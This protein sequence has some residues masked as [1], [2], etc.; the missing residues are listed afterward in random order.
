MSEPH[1]DA[2]VAPSTSR[3][4][5]QR[6]LRATVGVMLVLAL[7]GLLFTANARIA[8]SSGERHP[9]NLRELVQ[10]ETD[11]VAGLVA[12]VD[13][14]TG[15]IDAL[16]VAP[17]SG[18]SVDTERELRDGVAAGTVTVTGPGLFVALDDAPPSTPLTEDVRPDSLVVHQQDLEAVV[19]ALWAGGAEAMML[20]DQRV[21]ATTAFRCVGNVLSLGG[22]VYSPPYRVRAIGDPA[23]LRAAL[24]ASPEIRVYRQWADAVGLGWDVRDEA[25]LELPAGPVP[26]ALEHASVP[27]GTAVLP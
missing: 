12:T 14:L 18:T 3:S 2:P 22:R 6:P 17:T 23:A 9:T 8:R 7:A 19:N 5:A 25:A 1:V 24:D 15:Q 16:A 4:R 26:A 10:T 21:T 13:G 27:A 20:E 11:R